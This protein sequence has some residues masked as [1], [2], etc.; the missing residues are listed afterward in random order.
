[1][2]PFRRLPPLNALRSYEAAARHRSF[3]KAAE[4]L[5]V[6]PAAVSYQVRTLEDHVGVALFQRVKRQLVLTVAG[7]A[8]L[9]GIQGAF[10]GLAASINAISVAG[11]SG[12][13]TVSVAPSFASKWLLPRLHFFQAVH[14]DIDVRVSASMQLADFASGDVDLAIRY[15]TGRYP[16][17]VSEQILCESVIPVC[18]PKLL[19]SP[20]PLRSPADIRSHTLLHD[21]SPDEDESCPTWET[22]LNAAG[23]PGIDARRGP[24]F[25]QSSMVLE[26]AALGRGVALA[27]SALAAVDLA[28]A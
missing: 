19:E 12:V 14:P 7:R 9:P 28:E 4:E 10:E 26:A 23:V 18:S 27:K 8:C 16:G 6:T 15:G 5:G 17:L 3:S 22:W 24:R 13:L 20:D 11:R 25:D 2:K 21:D 1:M